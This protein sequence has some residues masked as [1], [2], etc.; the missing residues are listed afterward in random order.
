MSVVFFSCS[1]SYSSHFSCSLPPLAIL[2]IPRYPYFDPHPTLPTPDSPS[3][4]SQIFIPNL[5][6]AV[7]KPPLSTANPYALPNPQL[8]HV[9]PLP[10]PNPNPWPQPPT[11]SPKP[12]ISSLYPP[13][14]TPHLS[15][16]SP[17]PYTPLP[18]PCLPRD[19][20]STF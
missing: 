15:Y 6:Y 12:P 5:E 18:R 3:L 8:S 1:C 11:L 9:K 7:P 19:L 2:S 4:P 13:S 10:L 20:Y 17:N 16:E 14:H